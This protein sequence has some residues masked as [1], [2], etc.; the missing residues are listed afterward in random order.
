MTAKRDRADL[1]LVKHGYFESGTRA[2]L[3][4]M[5]GRVR[6][7]TDHVVRNAS[8]KVAIDAT[9]D[10][11]RPFPYVSR[12]A[13]KLEP[14]LDRHLPT[15]TDLIC[16]DV[17]ASTGGFTDLMLQ[18]GATKVYAVDVGTGQLHYKLQQDPRVVSF[19]KCNART[20]DSTIIP[21]SV[22][23]VTMDVSFI[24]VTKILPAVA[25][26]VKA[27]ALAFILVKPQFEAERSEIGRG[28][29]VRDDVVRLRVLEQICVFAEETLGWTRVDSIDSPIAGPKGNREIVA[30]FRTGD[31]M[32]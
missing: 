6:I 12:G 13:L 1:L 4:I 26:L 32:P 11:E 22:D 10:V 24:S 21:E 3:A 25:R 18:R 15:L 5:E 29:V 31:P 19:E 17:G 27:G 7:G 23:V 9:F 14:A 16:L 30:V 8:E 20:L 2:K 28:G